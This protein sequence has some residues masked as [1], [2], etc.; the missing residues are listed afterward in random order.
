M[1]KHI[2]IFAVLMLLLIWA[3]VRYEVVAFNWGEE[4]LLDDGI[5]IMIYNVNGTV[6]DTI[7]E[8]GVC[9]LDI[10]EEQ[11]PDILCLHELGAVGFSQIEQ[12][13]DS[14]YGYSDDQLLKK[15][16]DRY[17]L[18]S[19]FPIQNFRQYSGC[20]DVLVPDAD[21]LIDDEIKKLHEKMPI[22]SADIEVEKDRWITV[23]SCHLRS[24]AYSTARRSMDR[25]STTWF[26][27]IPLYYKN[28]KQ[29]HAIRNWEARQLRQYI[30]SLL[31]MDRPVIVAG[32]L[33]DFSGSDCLNLIMGR[34][35]IF[36]FLGGLAAVGREEL[37]DAWWERGNRFGITYDEWH[38]KLRLD[39][40]LVSRHFGVQRVVV[41]R[42]G[43]S[44]HYPVVVDMSQMGRVINE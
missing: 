1:K 24:N 14:I 26:D 19:R 10:V 44:D 32:D 20:G 12:S 6:E 11:K 15:N 7:H 16:R 17:V 8:D 35:S 22:F 39:H 29:A 18:Y 9:L 21:S 30:D 4:K 3:N 23:F 28:Y 33:N 25:D 34:H 37:R 41:P 5:R 13:L 2:S 36:P 27:G 43:L 38:L 40:I 42:H 31:A